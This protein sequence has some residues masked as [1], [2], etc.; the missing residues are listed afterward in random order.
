MGIKKEKIEELIE[1]LQGLL[2]TMEEYEAE[3]IELKCNTYGIGSN[4]I[5]FGNKGYLEI[6]DDYSY[7]FEEE[8]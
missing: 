6:S 3:E 8:K 5:S 1:N 7:K 2:D 4:F